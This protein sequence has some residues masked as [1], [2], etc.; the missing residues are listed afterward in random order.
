MLLMACR[1]PSALCSFTFSADFRKK[2]RRHSGTYHLTE[3]GSV[4]FY[5]VGGGGG[6][7]TGGVSMSVLTLQLSYFSHGLLQHSNKKLQMLL[8]ELLHLNF[9][10]LH[11]T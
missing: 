2:E 6:G 5:W 9:V 4:H 11:F 7:E 1:F 8:K 3:R 10:L